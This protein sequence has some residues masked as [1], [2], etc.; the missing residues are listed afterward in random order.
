MQVK[1]PPIMAA[2]ENTADPKNSLAVSEV[3]LKI[4]IN[5]SAIPYFNTR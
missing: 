5:F 3:A 2:T 1:A 4:P